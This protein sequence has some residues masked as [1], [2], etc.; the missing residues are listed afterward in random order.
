M[1]YDHR[2]NPRFAA[3]PPLR[4]ALVHVKGYLEITGTHRLRKPLA[5]HRHQSTSRPPGVNPTRIFESSILPCVI[6]LRSAIVANEL[7]S[8]W[9]VEFDTFGR[10]V[11]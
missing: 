10:L 7:K 2:Y 9:L 6:A 11:R 3:S 5:R 4:K 8:Y 1:D